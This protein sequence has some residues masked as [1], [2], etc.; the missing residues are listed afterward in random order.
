MTRIHSTAIGVAAALALAGSSAAEEKPAPLHK[1][2]SRGEVAGS[3]QAFP[4]ACRLKNG[5]ILAVFYAGYGHVSGPNAQWPKGGRI[6]MVRSSDE[7]RTWTR[8]EILFDDEL[9]NRDPHIAQMSDGT[10][11]C[12]LFS[13]AGGNGSVQIVRSRDGGR[14]WDA[15]PQTI[16]TGWY[17]SAPVREMPDGTYVLGIYAEGGGTAWG[18][19]TRSTDRGKTWSDPI[20]IGK[21]SGVRLDA[22]TDVVLLKDGSLYAALRGD[23]KPMHFATSRDLGL[24]WSPVTNIGF[25]AHCP[26]FTRLTSGEILLSHR[27]PGT[28]LHI[29]RDEGKSWQGP[30]PIDTVGGAYPATV[31]LKD[32]SVLAIYYEEGANSAI[33]AAR[34]RVKPE[35]IEKLPLDAE[36]A[37]EKAMS[38]P[39]APTDGDQN[40]ISKPENGWTDKK[41]IDLKGLSVTLSQPVLVARSKE[42]LWFPTLIDL[43]NGKLLAVMSNTG[44]EHVKPKGWAAWSSDGGL[45][46]RCDKPLDGLNHDHSALRMKNGDRALLPFYLFP[47]PG[48]NRVTGVCPIVRKGQTTIEMPEEGV[49][50]TGW[51]RACG[52]LGAFPQGPAG[53]GFA[54]NGQ[55]VGLEGGGYL[56]TLYGYFQG[57]RR[58]SLLAAESADGRDWRIRSVIADETCKL[59]GTAEGPC[60]AALC[61]LK[62][63]RLMCVFRMESCAPYGQC[64]S[65]DEGK[66]WT[67]PV[68]MA[69]ALSVQPSLAVMKDGMVALSG[70]RP[71]IFVWINADG[72]GN[73]WQAVDVQAHHNACCPTE[74]IG[75]ST[76]YTE[77]VATDDR[78]LLL[79]YDRGF[80]SAWVVRIGLFRDGEKTDK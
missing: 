4:D 43:E 53:A 72:T 5:D 39:A 74:T 28:S 64:W 24:T 50:V 69:Q 70:G 60:E 44:D 78:H 41:R 36:L 79:I 52:S 59:K 26:H 18:G 11:I 73:D 48:T 55:T 67:T 33:R 62:D 61:R 34:F 31:E 49:S 17:C 8:P 19:V 47:V 2:I 29:S 25:Q 15:K 13:V 22:E 35:G 7:G 46:W 30:Y 12:S 54:F 37:V 66:T 58:Y 45:T 65:R 1:V 23:G 21:E 40:G 56:A 32:K 14:T 16:L 3:Y 63:G 80:N 57:P 10:L 68:A 20:P 71:G 51:P 42:R 38:K 77:L 6:C 9:D 27:I 76:C 75:A